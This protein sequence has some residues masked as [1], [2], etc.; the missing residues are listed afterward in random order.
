MRGSGTRGTQITV[1]PM[2]SGE[3]QLI[4]PPITELIYP[5]QLLPALRGPRLALAEGAI[6]IRIGGPMRGLDEGFRYEGCPDYGDLVPPVCQDFMGCR[7][8]CT[9]NFMI[10]QV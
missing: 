9:S 10:S 8:A 3:V 6:L 4:E 2:E 5:I 1:T 7:Q